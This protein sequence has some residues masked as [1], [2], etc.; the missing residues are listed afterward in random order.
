[1]RKGIRFLIAVLFFAN[2]SSLN[3]IKKEDFNFQNSTELAKHQA[4]LL[5]DYKTG[6]PVSNEEIKNL[7]N[8]V[9]VTSAAVLAPGNLVIRQWCLIDLLKGKNR[10]EKEIVNLLICLS[11]NREL[12]AEGYSYWGYTREI[13]DEWLKKFGST[14]VAAI[15]KGVDAGF[16]RTAYK[17]NGVWYPAPFGDLRDVPLSPEL[18]TACDSLIDTATV[19][20]VSLK[21]ERNPLIIFYR[22]EAQPIGMNFHIPKR[23]TTIRVFNGIPLNF[24]FY[25]G[26]GNKYKSKEEEA[27][28]LLDSVRVKTIGKCK[29]Y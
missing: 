9:W 12:W 29:P 17:R 8:N 1:M 24:V 22:I 6:I 26:Y 14:D 11:Y 21:K 28:D 5:N 2:C 27:A 7:E 15:E 4:K 19:G 25:T 3:L 18:Q 13:L 20:I 16:V 10:H 23:N